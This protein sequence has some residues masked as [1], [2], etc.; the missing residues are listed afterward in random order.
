MLAT[1]AAKYEALARSAGRV[2]VS[3]DIEQDQGGRR[4][5]LC[6]QEQG[7]PTNHGA[8]EERRRHAADRAGVQ[9]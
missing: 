7:G 9:A 6:W 3:W 5:G 4:V 8:K 2:Q 1:N